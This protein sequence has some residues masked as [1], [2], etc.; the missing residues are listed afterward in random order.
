[1]NYSE[2]EREVI[3]TYESAFPRKIIGWTETYPDGFGESKKVLTSTGTKIKSIRS[4]Y[5]SKNK[6]IDQSMRK[7]LGLE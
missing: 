7:E 6:S 1:M 2:L 5:W 4:D 3:I